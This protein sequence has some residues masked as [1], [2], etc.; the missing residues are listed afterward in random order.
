[1]EHLMPEICDDC[2]GCA[3]MVVRLWRA[4]GGGTSKIVTPAAA[5]RPDSAHVLRPSAASR[6]APRYLSSS[7]NQHVIKASATAVMCTCSETL[8]TACLGRH[9]ICKVTTNLRNG[10]S[11]ASAQ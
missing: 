7:T 11:A 3:S 2:S 1:M 10:S 8:A 4:H 5:A 6:H 9:P